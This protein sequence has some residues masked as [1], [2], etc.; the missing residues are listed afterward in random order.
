MAPLDFEVSQSY[1]LS[2]EGRRHTQSL[3]DITTV[4]INVTDVN[5]NSPV[6]EE[7]GYRVEITEELPPGS[8][9]LKVGAEEQRED[10]PAGA[11]LL[12]CPRTWR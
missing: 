11:P 8:L 3:S 9:V 6:F 5:D 1:F 10:A 7:G 4:V 12:Q 2:V